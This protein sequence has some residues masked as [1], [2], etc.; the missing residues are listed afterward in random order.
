MVPCAFRVGYLGQNK[1]SEARG[2]ED[3]GSSLGTL[4]FGYMSEK[5][6]GMAEQGLHR[7]VLEGIRVPVVCVYAG[8]GDGCGQ[9]ATIG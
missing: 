7:G 2:N 3:D 5:R 9:H 4:T 6:I 8:F 1:A